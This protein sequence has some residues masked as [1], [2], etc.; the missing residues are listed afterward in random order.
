LNKITHFITPNL[1]FPEFSLLQQINEE[2]TNNDDND[3]KGKGKGKGVIANVKGASV[4]DE[5]IKIVLVSR[6]NAFT[7]S[8]YRVYETDGVNSSVSQ[9]SWVTRSFDLQAIQQYVLPTLFSFRK[10]SLY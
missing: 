6:T 9:P 8:C 5:K 1:D 3:G 10:S 7:I 2:A 4:K